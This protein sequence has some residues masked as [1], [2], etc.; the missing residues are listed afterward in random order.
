MGE[1]R[2]C[3]EH[4]TSARAARGEWQGDQ[5]ERGDEEGSEEEAPPEGRREY[6]L[7]EQFAREHWG[8]VSPPLST[9]PTGAARVL[10]PAHQPEGRLARGGTLVARREARAR[11]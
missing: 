4:L 3:S 7:D 8:C 6:P 5:H 11:R 10:R 9:R 2:V 1:K